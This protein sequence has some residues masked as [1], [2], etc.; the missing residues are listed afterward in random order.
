M[1]VGFGLSLV[2]PFAL[3][4]VPALSAISILL[5]LSIWGIIWIINGV[6]LAL[7]AFRADQ[8][9][10]LGATTGLFMVWTYNYAVSAVMEFLRTGQTRYWLTTVIF[11]GMV[12]ALMGLARMVNPAPTH[13][14]VVESAGPVPDENGGEEE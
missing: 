12:I 3:P 8:A 1:S 10:A 4:T 11:A 5:P 14:E 13:L 7:A 2:G 9:K 6:F